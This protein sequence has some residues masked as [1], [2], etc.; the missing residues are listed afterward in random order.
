[1]QLLISGEARTGLPFPWISPGSG[2]DAGAGR[3]CLGGGSGSTIPVLS[4]ILRAPKAPWLL[5]N[6][7]LESWC[8]SGELDR[9]L[10]IR[11]TVTGT[12][13]RPTG[14]DGI[15]L[16][17]CGQRSAREQFLF[18]SPVHPHQVSPVPHQNHELEKKESRGN[19]EGC[20]EGFSPLGRTDTLCWEPRT[21]CLWPR[22]SPPLPCPLCFKKQ[23]MRS[24]R[25]QKSSSCS[26]WFAAG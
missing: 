7:F 4:G 21:R 24:Q 13:P 17:V 22:A 6:P 16:G 19:G 9:F 20:W 3:S 23:R 26:P 2:R 12:C 5:H 1:M 11:D 14:W 18:T 25:S 10:G 15:P 8:D